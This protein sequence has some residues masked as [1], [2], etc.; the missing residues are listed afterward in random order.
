MEGRSDATWMIISQK[1]A[2]DLVFRFWLLEGTNQR[3]IVP[4]IRKNQQVFILQNDQMNQNGRAGSDNYIHTKQ[5]D[6]YLRLLNKKSVVSIII[7]AER[8]FIMWALFEAVF[9]G[10]R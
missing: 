1:W 7:P 8:E 5:R 6:R 2:V 10:K 3:F 4:T 9:G